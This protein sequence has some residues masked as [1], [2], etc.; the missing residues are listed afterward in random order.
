MIK[1]FVASLFLI[2][3]GQSQAGG[4]WH[5][6]DNFGIRYGNA[7]L[8]MD[9][10]LLKVS[11]RE[12]EGLPRLFAPETQLDRVSADS[13]QRITYHFT[14][15]NAAGTTKGDR[16]H[17]PANIV[18]QEMCGDQRLAMFYKNGVTVEYHYQTRAGTEAGRVDARPA[19][20]GYPPK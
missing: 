15:L 8:N 17:R 5:L 1:R 16:P 6:L 19:D 12:N 14:L 20:C 10:A 2:T 11:E 7:D 4:A 13:G 9:S 3:S 18:R